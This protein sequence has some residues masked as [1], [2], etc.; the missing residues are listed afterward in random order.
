MSKSETTEIA[1]SLRDFAASDELLLNQAEMRRHGNNWVAACGAKVVAVAATL[2]AIRDQLQRDR[3]PMARV[4]IR[5]IEKDGA[6]AV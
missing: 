3:I 4:A 5:F 2:P 6:A 1:E